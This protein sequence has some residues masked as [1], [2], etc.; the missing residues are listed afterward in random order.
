MSTSTSIGSSLGAE[1]PENSQISNIGFCSLI[2]FRSLQNL[3]NT[4]QVL[5]QYDASER[6]ESETSFPNRLVSVFARIKG[7][8]GVVHVYESQPFKAYHI[9]EI[10]PDTVVIVY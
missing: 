7:V 4:D 9:I 1:R 10:S 8:L 5:V 6:L 2:A 3:G